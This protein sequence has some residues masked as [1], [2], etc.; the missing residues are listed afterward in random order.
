MRAPRCHRSAESGSAFD[1]CSETKMLRAELAAGVSAVMAAT[2]SFHDFKL[3][4]FYGDVI[5]K[6][7]GQ[8]RSKQSSISKATT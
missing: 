2:D 3:A 6:N 5:Q 8:H 4:S 7:G 1:E